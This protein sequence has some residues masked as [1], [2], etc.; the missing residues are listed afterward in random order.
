LEQ[1][2]PDVHTKLIAYIADELAAEL[3]ADLLARTEERVTLLDPVGGEAALRADVAGVDSWKKGV[4]PQWQP[5][6]ETHGGVIHD[7]PQIVIVEELTERWVEILDKNGRLITVIEVLSPA[8]KSNGRA[9]YQARRNACIHAGVNLVEIDL[10]RAGGHVV[11]AP[12][13]RVR[14]PAGVCYLVCVT[15]SVDP[16]RREL[17][18]MPLRRP[19]ATI[20]VPLREEDADILLPLQPLVD[21]CYQMG[22]Y[23]NADY[24]QLPGPALDPEDAAWVQPQVQAAGLGR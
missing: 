16:T 9:A 13:Q 8:N 10:L 19:L 21:R 5:G 3:P 15:R 2:W 24:S 18:V 4:V 20:R 11:A 22:R 17:H 14:R 1:H 7:E 23:W 12:M 6:A